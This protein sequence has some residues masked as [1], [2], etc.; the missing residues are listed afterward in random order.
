MRYKDVSA[1]KEC[2]LFASQSVSSHWHCAH[3]GA[4]CCSVKT[5]RVWRQTARQAW[6]RVPGRQSFEQF[7]PMRVLGRQSLEQFQPMR[8]LGRQSLEQFQQSDCH[9]RYSA[10][11]RLNNNK[12][13]KNCTPITNEEMELPRIPPYSKPDFIQICNS[14][15]GYHRWEYGAVN[16]PLSLSLISHKSVLLQSG[17]TAENMKLPRIP[18]PLSL[19]LGQTIAVAYVIRILPS[20][21]PLP[22]PSRR[23]NFRLPGSANFITPQI[24]S[25]HK[26]TCVKRRTSDLYLKVV[27]RAGD[28]EESVTVTKWSTEQMTVKNQ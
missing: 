1:K 27:N 2:G 13:N 3:S 12:H 14:A 23:F 25:G 18:N 19:E 15:E 7:Q 6:W 16:D 26:V 21:L 20:P 10:R 5:I 9:K 22:T 24:Y 28:S 4:L 8:V 11:K 17:T